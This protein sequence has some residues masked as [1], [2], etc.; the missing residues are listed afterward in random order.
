M[1]ASK[2]SQVDVAQNGA[3]RFALQDAVAGGQHTPL[4]T[5]ELDI[6]AA[7]AL[8]AALA[9]VCQGPRRLPAS[10]P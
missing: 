5:A 3:S 7:P 6:A 2:H 8:E 10:T 9:K 4:L 1:S